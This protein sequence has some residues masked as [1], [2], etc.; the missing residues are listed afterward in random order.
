MSAAMARTVAITEA[1]ESK[2]MT[3]K[4]GTV[5]LNLLGN[6]KPITI[7]IKKFDHRTMMQS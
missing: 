4:K 2:K 1:K 6:S 7:M 5:V 3:S